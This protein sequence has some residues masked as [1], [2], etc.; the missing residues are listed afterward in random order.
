MMIGRTV[1]DRVFRS[2][3]STV[4]AVDVR[5]HDVEDDEADR[6]ALDHA[7]GR[8]AVRGNHDVVPRPLQAA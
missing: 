6:L 5:H 4:Y 7:E 1:S 8:V 2:F 3:S